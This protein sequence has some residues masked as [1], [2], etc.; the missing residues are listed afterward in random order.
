M[1]RRGFFSPLGAL[2]AF[3]SR[4]SVVMTVTLNPDVR[5]CIGRSAGPMDGADA[6]ER[7]AGTDTAGTRG[8]WVENGK[9]VVGVAGE[10]VI[11]INRA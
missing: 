10:A 7:F 1:A 11:R 6:H 8:R 4:V 3:C 9:A 2:V 5:F